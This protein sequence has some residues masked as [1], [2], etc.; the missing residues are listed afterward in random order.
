MTNFIE[1]TILANGSP[2]TAL[3][4]MSDIL[5]VMGPDDADAE[6]GANSVLLLS[7]EHDSMLCTQTYEQVKKLLGCGL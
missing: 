2:D 3:V 7:N 5:A 1:L 6:K 4:N